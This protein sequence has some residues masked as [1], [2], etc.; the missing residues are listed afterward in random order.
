[1]RNANANSDGDSDSYCDA[2]SHSDTNGNRNCNSYGNSD[3]HTNGDCDGYSAASDCNADGHAEEDAACGF[4][5]VRLWLLSA[6]GMPQQA[7]AEGRHGQHQQRGDK[8][9]H[10]G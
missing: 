7:A 4:L 2:D 6:E 9:F 5:L 1:M 8:G 3:G 10:A